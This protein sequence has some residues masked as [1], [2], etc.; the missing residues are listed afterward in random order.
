MF[1]IPQTNT[2][3]LNLPLDTNKVDADYKVDSLCDKKKDMLELKVLHNYLNRDIISIIEEYGNQI[4][5]E[6]SQEEIK[7]LL[8]IVKFLS[9]PLYIEIYLLLQKNDEKYSKNISGVWFDFNELNSI[10]QSKLYEMVIESNC[11]NTERKK[12]K[13][14]DQYYYA[15]M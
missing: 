5:I 4:Y 6:L 1:I 9:M 15:K 14:Y 12:I 2:L 13:I 10:T 8:G 3:I 7:T 11:S